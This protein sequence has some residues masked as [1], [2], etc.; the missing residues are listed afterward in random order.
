V[1]TSPGLRAHLRLFFLRSLSISAL[2]LGATACSFSPP[3]LS[4]PPPP[5]ADVP[6]DQ[7]SRGGE[8]Y[9]ETC[10]SCHG[11]RGEGTEG[12]PALIGETALPIEPNPASKTRKG[13]L[14]NARDLF[15]FVK[16][17]M[18]ALAPGSL[19]DAQAWSLVAYLLEQNGADLHGK[20]LDPAASASLPLHR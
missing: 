14:A 2:A 16:S 1:I 17:D 10:A 20:D 18:P 8:L 6:L 19:D 13:K 5:G 3:A 7:A 12:R 11:E 15:T 4:V 9:A